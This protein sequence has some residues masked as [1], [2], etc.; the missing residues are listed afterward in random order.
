MTELVEFLVKQLAE[1]KD[2]VEI[3]EQDG[4]VTVKLAKSDMG[5]VIGRQGKIIK[6]IRTVVRAA[7][8]KGVKTSVEV[9]EKEAEVRD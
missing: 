2:E 3:S 9:I 8:P 5:K 4:C 6:A 7:A 1:N